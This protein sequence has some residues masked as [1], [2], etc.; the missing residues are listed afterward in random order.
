MGSQ[1][2]IKDIDFSIVD[3]VNDLIAL[4]IVVLGSFKTELVFLWW[5]QEVLHEL[6]DG[7]SLLPLGTWEPELGYHGQGCRF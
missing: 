6:V 2:P 5:V 7:I 3:Q 4:T 1:I